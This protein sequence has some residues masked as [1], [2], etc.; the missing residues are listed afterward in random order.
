MPCLQQLLHLLG[1]AE[2]AGGAEEQQQQLLLLL[3]EAG[4]QHLQHLVVWLLLAGEEQLQQ[5]LQHLL[6]LPLLLEEEE[7]EEAEAEGRMACALDYPFASG[8]MSGLDFLKEHVSAHAP[9]H[10]NMQLS[11]CA[12]FP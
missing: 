8:M 7:D 11:C 12:C 1:E 10:A 2:E 3:E 9:V 6:F 4:G 5:R